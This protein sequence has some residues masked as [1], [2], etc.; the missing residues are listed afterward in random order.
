MRKGGLPVTGKEINK[1]PEFN[2]LKA[3]GWMTGWYI[4]SLLTLFLNKTILSMPDGDE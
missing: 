1:E 2:L 4:C 3:A